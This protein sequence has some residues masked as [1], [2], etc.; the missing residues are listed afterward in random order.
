M[1]K[2]LHIFIGALILIVLFLGFASAENYCDIKLRITCD[3]ENGYAVM[4]L[5][6]FTNAHGELWNQANYD[7]VLCCDFEED[8][9]CT[10][11]N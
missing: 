11:T 4:G 10:G 2:R 8:N 9:D 6:D 1:Q 5:S 3:S 7:Y